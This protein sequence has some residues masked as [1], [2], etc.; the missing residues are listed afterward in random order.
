MTLRLVSAA[1]GIPLLFLVVWAGTLWLMLLVSVIAAVGAVETLR[2]AGHTRRSYLIIATA[3]FALIFV[4]VPGT[5]AITGQPVTV[6]AYAIAVATIASL[7]YLLRFRALPA[8]S[9]PMISVFPAAFYPA[10]F[11]A[12]AVL[13]RSLP[14]G[15]SW[16]I[17]LLAVTFATDTAALFVGKA[18]GRHRLAP[19][20]SPGK[21]WEGAAGGMVGAVGVAAAAFYILELPTSLTSV[22]VLAA[23]VG[24]AGQF[25]DLAES[26]LK[27]VAGVKDS[28]WIIPGHG[29][30]LDRLDSIVFNLV[31]VYYFVV[32]IV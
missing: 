22:L 21:T 17:L 30:V 6:P 14:D 2:L 13:L 20:I 12:H 24:A 3:G 19:S 1:V 9:N 4:A 5:L 7:I 32:W 31:V 15:F 26:R 10:G 23:F 11:L 28:G 18:I 25:G 29:G 16:L 8:Y 27:R